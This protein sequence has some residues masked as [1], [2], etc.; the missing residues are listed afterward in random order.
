MIAVL[1]LA[2]LCAAAP[3][4]AEDAWSEAYYRATDATRSLS[5]TEQVELDEACIGFMKRCHADLVLLAVRTADYEGFTLREA[6]SDYYEDCGFGYGE[7]KDGFFLV[8]DAELKHA[9]IY[10]C[11]NAETLVAQERLDS[12]AA[13][14]SD[15]G[16][17]DSVYGVFRTAVETLSAYIDA[18]LTAPA[19]GAGGLPA[20]YP[21]D[22]EHFEGFHDPDAPRVVDNADLFTDAEEQ[23]METRLAALREELSKD[24]VIYTDVTS[25]GK[26]HAYYAADFYDYNGYGIGENYEGVCL[27]VCMDPE[28]RGWWACGTGPI[29]EELYTEDNANDLDDVLYEYMVEGRY[30]EGVADWI[31][32]IRTM[33]VKGVPFAPDWFPDL[34]KEA[35]RAHNPSA[36]RIADEAGQLSAEARG[37]LE[38]RAAEIAQNYDLDVVVLITSSTAGLELRDY[39]EKFYYYNGYGFGENYDGI[40]LT[41][42]HRGHEDMAVELT[43]S[44]KGADRL[45]D[46]NRERLL[47]KAWGEM[48]YHDGD[49]DGLRNYLNR[50][51]HMER[52]GRVARSAGYWVW[53]A[54]VAVAAGSI[55]GAITLSGAKKR[56]DQPRE[57]RNAN[58]YLV[59]NLLHIS[60]LGS[61]FLYRTESKCYS[62]V[63]EERTE[64][65]SP[66]SSSGS[67]SRSSSYSKS[68]TSSSGRSHTGSGRKF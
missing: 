68:Y 63:R 6:S 3:A 53:I 46:V 42:L 36:P 18:D 41:V 37:E 48:V 56:M 61:T 14:L 39:A 17:A 4:A 7:T 11:G 32:N 62:P 20:W 40:L 44:G 13:L 29:S 54:V 43:A 47:K 27:F 23:R 31:E 30:A 58:M 64:S 15:E 60:S 33:Y 45:T 51:D 50:L 2:A 38:A 52:T 12:I 16:K 35:P 67:H 28:D 22:T 21:A 66:R 1:L 55:F 49:Y 8:Y 9:E 34:G 10:A 19:P 59:P 57:Q 5:E 24:I 65:S 26:E 25:Y